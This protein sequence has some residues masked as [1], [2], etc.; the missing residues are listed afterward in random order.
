[1]T[2][3]QC[4]FCEDWFHWR[5]RSFVICLIS[6]LYA[7]VAFIETCLITALVQHLW[8]RTCTAEELPVPPPLTEELELAEMVCAR[9][10]SEHPFVALYRREL[11]IRIG[12][13]LEGHAAASGP[14][15]S[16]SQS[17]PDSC[18]EPAAKS[19]K[20]ELA[21]ASLSSESASQPQAQAQECST[22]AKDQEH[23]SAHNALLEPRNQSAEV[24]KLDTLDALPEIWPKDSPAFFRDS[25]REQL[26]RCHHCLVLIHYFVFLL[27]LK[28]E[29]TAYLAV[30][31]A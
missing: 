12:D 25:W 11:G 29:S 7:F 4:V 15:P 20:L 6:F 8:P 17:E 16:P 10:V 3:L 30:A 9:C 27:C 5:V 2:M 14:G 18:S 24:C 23:K 19:R 13:M 21:S 28:F 31:C 22:V 1:M 26:C